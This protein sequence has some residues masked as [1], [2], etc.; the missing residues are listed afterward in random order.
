MISGYT[1]GEMNY[2]QNVEIANFTTN[3]TISGLTP[4]SNSFVTCGKDSNGNLV[5]KNPFDNN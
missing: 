4:G 2:L 5:T 1:T 3:V